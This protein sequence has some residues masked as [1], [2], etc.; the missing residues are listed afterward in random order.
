MAPW[1]DV[2]MAL[3]AGMTAWPGDPMFRRDLVESLER[4]DVATVSALHLSSHTGTHVDA[5]AHF[6]AGAA[7]IDLAPLDVLIGRVRVV[8]VPNQKVVDVEAL[9]AIAP[10]SG[11]RL[12][13]RTANSDRRYLQGPFTMDYVAPTAAAARFLVQCGVALVGV[14]SLSVGRP[15]DGVETH[16][17]LLG[18]GIWVIEGLDLTDVAAGSYEMLCLPLRI[19]GGDGAPARVLLR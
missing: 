17:I 2:S 1:R 13:L 10:Q 16:R 12:L 8:A 3:H 5:P 19:V 7:S 4:G 14:D 15:E 9:R 18:A 6:V 11:E